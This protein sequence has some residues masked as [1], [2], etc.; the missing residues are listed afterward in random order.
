MSEVERDAAVNGERALSGK[1]DL[2]AGSGAI[3]LV[4][5]PVPDLDHL[6]VDD[7]VGEFEGALPAYRQVPVVVLDRA[8][9][10]YAGVE[11]REGSIWVGTRHGGLFQLRDVPFQAITRRQGLAHDDVI[12]VIED[13]SGK[14]WVGTDGAGLTQLNGDKSFT[15]TIQEGLPSNVI[16][17]IAETREMV[18]ALVILTFLVLVA[19]AIALPAPAHIRASQ[20]R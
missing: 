12:S 17:T 15:W 11:D 10:R 1:F 6:P 20:T 19:R 4:P 3:G 7:L 2:L 13:R 18:C 16:W 8:A 9:S 5:P 14:L